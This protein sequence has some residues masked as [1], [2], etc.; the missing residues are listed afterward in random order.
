VAGGWASSSSQ[1]HRFAFASAPSADARSAALQLPLG[2]T[3]V[4]TT[5]DPTTLIAIVFP[6]DAAATAVAYL[7]RGPK[8]N[9]WFSGDLIGATLDLRAE[10]GSAG[11]V[12]DEAPRLR[13]TLDTNRVSG[14]V[15]QAGRSLSYVAYPAT[16]A[17]GLY[18]TERDATGLVRGA[19]STGATLE[20]QQVAMGPGA[21]DAP[22]L[23]V[24]TITLANG[25]LVNL[26]VPAQTEGPAVFRWIALAGGQVRGAGRRRS[27]DNA[28]LVSGDLEL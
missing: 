1:A 15:M 4:G 5:S 27:P 22:F 21:K 24:G 23:I 10:P 11:T 6:A 12:G 14:E 2:A 16:G 3:Y 17:A 26:V 13:G 7:C 25:H 19:A 8:L 20:A 9:I 18:Y 28:T